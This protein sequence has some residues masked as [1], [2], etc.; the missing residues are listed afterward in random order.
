MGHIETTAFK[1]AEE[2]LIVE[3]GDSRIKG[4]SPSFKEKPANIGYLA[5]CNKKEIQNSNILNAKN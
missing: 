3:G 5:N 4:L 2:P 1:F